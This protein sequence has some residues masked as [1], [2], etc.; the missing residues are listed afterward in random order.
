MSTGIS[1]RAGVGLGT[2]AFALSIGFLTVVRVNLN[3]PD[4]LIHS[5]HGGDSKLRS[6]VGE[7][8]PAKSTGYWALCPF[9]V[10]GMLQTSVMFAWRNLRRL[11]AGRVVH[12]RQ[13]L[14]LSDGGTIALDY[15]YHRGNSLPL[16]TT[17]PP[18]RPV[19]ILLHG[20]LGDARSEYLY[21]LTGQLLELG[22][23]PVVV[24]SRGCGDLQLTTSKSFS[25]F[26]VDDVHEALVHLRS[27]LF[28][29]HRFVGVGFSLGAGQLLKYLAQERSEVVKLDLSIAISP[30]WSIS[31]KEPLFDFFWSP[32]LVIPLKIFL[33]RH[34]HML[35]RPDIP[36]WKVLLTPNLQHWDELFCRAYGLSNVEEYY[37]LGSAATTAHLIKTPTIAVSS[38]DDGI[39]S[40]K[41][42]PLSISNPS[43]ALLTSHYGGHLAFPKNN[44]SLGSWIDDFIV[45]AIVRVHEQRQLVHSSI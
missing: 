5:L 42:L 28:K 18:D 4:H 27:S 7:C 15:A 44:L 29:T 33:I 24:V 9:D 40:A 3:K 41:G 37:A 12:Q 2:A 17:Y 11:V 43:L 6:F 10:G 14:P 26:D 23:Q 39:C 34:H 22:Y 31:Q 19:V 45:S 13:L 32:L 8:L 25:W 30:P 35:K 38:L 21:S 36:L 16:D 20:M 1:E